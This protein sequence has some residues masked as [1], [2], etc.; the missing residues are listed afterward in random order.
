M[1]PPGL[2]WL[3]R[4]ERTEMSRL[5][6]GDVTVFLTLTLF[7]VIFVSSPVFLLYYFFGKGHGTKL[8]Y[9]L[10]ACINL[11]QIISLLHK[12]QVIWNSFLILQNSSYEGLQ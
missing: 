2:L 10:A 1:F 12:P 7:L 8:C 9:Y 3:G 6:F 11:S 4:F 5:L